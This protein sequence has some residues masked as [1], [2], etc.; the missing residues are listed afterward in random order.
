MPE[1]VRRQIESRGYSFLDK[2]ELLGKKELTAGCGAGTL[3]LANVVDGYYCEDP[4]VVDGLVG[5]HYALA[6]Q[7]EIQS[8]MA[9]NPEQG[10]GGMR[11]P[12]YYFVIRKR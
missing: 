6:H 11:Y 9:R 7:C 3:F 4:L 2:K 5:M 1:T 10:L 8:K 12:G